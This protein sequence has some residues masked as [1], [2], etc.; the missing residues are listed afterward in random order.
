MQIIVSAFCNERSELKWYGYG[1][2]EWLKELEVI[3]IND[4][5]FKRNIN[6]LRMGN[7]FIPGIWYFGAVIKRDAKKCLRNIKKLGGKR[8]D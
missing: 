5:K 6:I 7:G 8:N 4:G 2:I 3:G 1:N